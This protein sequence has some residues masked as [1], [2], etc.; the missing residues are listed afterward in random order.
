MKKWSENILMVDGASEDRMSD[1]ED[2][3]PDRALA[4]INNVPSKAL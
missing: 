3:S 2:S 4:P 1:D